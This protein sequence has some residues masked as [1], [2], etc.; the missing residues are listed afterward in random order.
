MAGWPGKFPAKR[1]SSRSTGRHRRHLNRSGF[2]RSP[3]ATHEDHAVVVGVAFRV[4]GNRGVAARLPVLA[5]NAAERAA[6]DE[7]VG[8]SRVGPVPPTVKG[9]GNSAGSIPP[10]VIVVGGNN[11]VRVKGVLSDGGFILCL[12]ASLQVCVRNVQAVLID[13]DVVPPVLG[14]AVITGGEVVAKLLPSCSLRAAGDQARNSRG[15]P[16]AVFGS[17]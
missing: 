7:F 8:G 16:G 13:L 17:A 14:T 1:R 10:S 6:T 4:P 2:V 15:R 12:P 3:R 9:V 11:V 5:G